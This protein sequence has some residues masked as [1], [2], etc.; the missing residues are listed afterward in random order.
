MI[1]SLRAAAGQLDVRG[2]SGATREGD[3]ANEDY[4]TRVT[5]EPN[6][7]NKF[8]MEEKR[9]YLDEERDDGKDTPE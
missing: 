7:A 1:E 4:P 2:K 6:V 5:T 3:V 8:G 9:E